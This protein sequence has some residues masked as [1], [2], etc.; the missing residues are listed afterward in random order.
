MVSKWM[1]TTLLSYLRTH[2][3]ADRMRL[4]SSLAYTDPAILI[5]E[6]QLLGITR[7]LHHLHSNGVIHGCLKGVGN[8]FNNSCHRHRVDLSI[9]S[10]V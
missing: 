2:P 9:F 10:L 4:V 1:D 8:M 7:G 3:Q 5:S 6:A